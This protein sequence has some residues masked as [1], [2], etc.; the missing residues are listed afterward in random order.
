MQISSS[1]QIVTFL[2][3]TVRIRLA[4]TLT[5]T[6]HVALASDVLEKGDDRVP[7]SI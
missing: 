4:H 6:T 5:S 3:R 7:K 1:D 2:I